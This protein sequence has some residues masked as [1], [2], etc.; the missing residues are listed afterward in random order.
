MRNW[1]KIN[2]SGILFGITCIVLLTLAACGPS[3][4]E[5]AA[6]EFHRLDSL[7]GDS[8]MKSIQKEYPTNVKVVKVDTT[9]PK[10]VVDNNRYWSSIETGLPCGRVVDIYC[11]NHE[12][13]KHKDHSHN[14]ITIKRRN[15][16]LTIV[17]NVDQ[18]ILF[19]LE[20]GDIITDK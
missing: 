5:Y 17:K 1:L 9:K 16:I 14:Y 7:R 2:G 20:I 6:R 12:T 3:A 13:P 19:N 8:I 4:E 10:P 11:Y 15:G 18:Y